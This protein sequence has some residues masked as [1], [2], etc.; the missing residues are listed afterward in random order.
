V[1]SLDV[2]VAVI[3]CPAA[4]PAAG[5]DAPKGVDAWLVAPRIVWPTNTSPSPNPRESHAVLRKYSMM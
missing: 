2:A 5:N 4:K 3:D 1:P